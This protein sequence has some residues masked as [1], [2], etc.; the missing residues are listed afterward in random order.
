MDEAIDWLNTKHSDKEISTTTTPP[1]GMPLSVM[2]TLEIVMNDAID[3]FQ[4]FFLARPHIIMG[5]ERLYIRSTSGSDL[6][7]FPG[8]LFPRILAQMSNL[9]HLELVLGDVFNYEEEEEEE[10]PDPVPE[11]DEQ[12]AKDIAPAEDDI[13]GHLYEH[14][15]HNLETLR[16]RGP[17][18]LAQK[19]IFK[20]WIEH[21]GKPDFLP[22]LKS[23][24]FVLDLDENDR[25]RASLEDLRMAKSQVVLLLKAAEARGVAQDDSWDQWAQLQNVSSD[26]DPRWA[27]ID[28]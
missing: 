9:K 4:R 18:Q 13:L 20:Q 28:A 26:I 8:N 22:S 17:I 21:F 14:L 6:H 3:T 23:L 11:R 10:D 12:I 15:P 24:S 16:V 2:R 7:Y 27:E 19:E 5:L 25:E 1:D